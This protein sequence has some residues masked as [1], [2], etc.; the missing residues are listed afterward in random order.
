MS[1]LN[2]IDAF[3]KPLKAKAIRREQ[4]WSLEIQTTKLIAIFIT[5]NVKIYLEDNIEKIL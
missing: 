2:D 1:N 5:V 4:S 3:N